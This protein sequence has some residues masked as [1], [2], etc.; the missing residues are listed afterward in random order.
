MG[1]KGIGERLVDGAVMLDR[2]GDAGGDVFGKRGR[3][4]IGRKDPSALWIKS[5]RSSQQEEAV[6]Y[7]SILDE[8]DKDELLVCG[9]LDG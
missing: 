1:V 2:S 3:L 7:L 4:W 6:S 5:G 8:L 9:D